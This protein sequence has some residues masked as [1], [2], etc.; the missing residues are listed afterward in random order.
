MMC[1]TYVLLCLEK[2]I[3][4]DHAA[5]SHDNLTYFP[6]ILGVRFG[7]YMKFWSYRKF[8]NFE[9]RPKKFQDFTLHMSNKEWSLR[10]LKKSLNEML[11]R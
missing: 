5:C 4:F 9:I 10:W 2:K 8:Q 7:F 3:N 11:T 6:T 1:N